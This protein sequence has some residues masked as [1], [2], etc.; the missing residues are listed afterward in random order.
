MHGDIGATKHFR[1]NAPRRL[2]RNGEERVGALGGIEKRLYCSWGMLEG[3]GKREL[4]LRRHV[5]EFTRRP[6]D[7]PSIFA[8]CRR[9]QGDKLQP[10]RCGASGEIVRG[11]QEHL[12]T[13]SQQLTTEPEERLD[14]PGG[15]ECSE[16]E[17]HE[18]PE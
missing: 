16:H 6:E 1:G 8:I 17:P 11:A 5:P 3:V 12:V 15:S 13:P 9:P 18:S 7:P 4:H 10:H 14:I 2:I